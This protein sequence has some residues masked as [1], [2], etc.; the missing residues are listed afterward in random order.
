M[1]TSLACA[2]TFLWASL[3]PTAAPA[4]PQFDLNVV[5]CR[6]YKSGEFLEC[7]KIERLT[8]GDAFVRMHA[9]LQIDWLV[10]EDRRSEKDIFLRWEFKPSD[11][12]PVIL[13][14]HRSNDDYTWEPRTY[15]DPTRWVVNQRAWPT[16][17]GTYTFFVYDNPAEPK[18]FLKSVIVEVVE[19]GT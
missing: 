10:S 1:R 18:K 14:N 11:G 2:N 5:V 17:P 7:N 8:E 15:N 4:N 19:Q 16:A 13:S 12:E 6:D 3:V 9:V